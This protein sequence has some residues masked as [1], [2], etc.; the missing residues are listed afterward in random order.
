[1]GKA[2]LDPLA[3]G[4]RVASHHVA[5]PVLAGMRADI[6]LVDLIPGFVLEAEIGIRR[7][8]PADPGEQQRGSEQSTGDTHGF[9]LSLAAA[10]GGARNDG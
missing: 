9:F 6:D 2:D 3:I 4:E 8:R 5:A 10:W 1:M 7:V